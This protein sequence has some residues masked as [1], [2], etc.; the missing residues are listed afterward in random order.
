MSKNEQSLCNF[1]TMLNSI[2]DEHSTLT[3]F[4]AD[5]GASSHMTYSKQFLTNLEPVDVIIQNGNNSQ[6][7]CTQK[8][9][10]KGYMLDTQGNF[11]SISLSNVLY[12]PSLTVN[13]L[14]IT[15]CLS[16][17]NVTLSGTN[18][19]LSLSFNGS[20]VQFTKKLHRGSGTLFAVDI[21]PQE[22]PTEI[23]IESTYLTIDYIQ[24]HNMMG[25]ANK[26][27]LLKTAK[28]Q[29]IT[30]TNTTQPPC[31]HCAKAKIRMKNMPKSTTTKA[32]SKGERLFIDLAW[33]KTASFANNRYW[34]LVMDDFTNFIW[35]FFLKSKDQL[36]EKVIALLHD[37]KKNHNII[38]HHIRCDN[39]GE[40]QTLQQMLQAD[41]ILT[42][43]FE[44]TAPDTPQQNGKIERKFATLNGKVRAMLNHAEFTWT[45]RN[46][47]WS[48]CA[49]LATKLD[50]LLVI[51]PTNQTPY[52][53]FYGFTPKWIPYLQPFG[54]MAIVKH[55]DQIQAKL[56]NR[57]FP[58]IY[59]GPAEDH[60]EDVYNFWNPITRK[61]I[62]SRTAIFILQSYGKYYK[63]EPSKR[64]HLIAALKSPSTEQYDDDDP[65]DD[66]DSNNADIDV[67]L[68]DLIAPARAYDNVTTTDTDSLHDFTSDNDSDSSPAALPA[69]IL[70]R[71]SGVP[72]ALSQLQTFYNPTPGVD[73][74]SESTLFNLLSTNKYIESAYLATMFNTSPEPQTF[75]ES[76]QCHD[77]PLWWKAVSLEFM[78]MEEKQ[79]WTIILK[80]N[81]P[82]KRHIIGT[83]WVF[84]Q[85]EDGRYR[86]RCVAKGFSQI[87]GKDFQEHHAP[88]ITDTTTHL[89]FVLQTIL[90][91]SNGQFDIETAFL[92]GDLDEKLWME[93]PD[94]YI[95][96]LKEK[97]L[98]NN[99]IYINI[100]SQTHCLLLTKAIYGLVQAARQWWKKFKEVLR[101]LYYFPSRADPCLFIKTDRLNNKSYLIIYVD[102]GGIFGTPEEIKHVLT[103]LSKTFVVKDL[104]PM[105]TFVGCKIITNKSKDTVWLHQPKLFKHLKEQFGS[106]I[107]NIKIHKTPASPKTNILRPDADDVLLQPLDQTKFRSGVGMLLYLVKHTRFD[108][109]NAVRELSKVADGANQAHWKALLRT[110][111]YTIETEHLAIKLKPTLTDD[112]C[113]EL[114]GMSDSDYAGDKQTRTSVFGYIIYF[115]GAPIAWKSKASKSVTLSST[116]AEYV[117]LSEI[118]KE[119]MFVKQVLETMNIKIKLPITVR[120]DN[121]GAIYLSNNFSLGQRTKHID[122]RHHFVREFVEDGI[123]KTIFIPTNDN[124]ADIFTKNTSEDTFN[125]HTM[126]HLEDIR[127]INLQ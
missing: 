69:T 55:T 22:S 82:L 110:I 35:S 115:C 46:N 15:K 90:R 94:G 108:I 93:L 71:F 125:R 45:L 40:N 63:I 48:Y 53:L 120:V 76:Q 51:A 5:T 104:G 101:T 124:D 50:N 79:V 36:Q 113:F 89:L 9:T 25:H 96:Y 95:R 122:I 52:N 17:N 3:T 47:M 18:Q 7:S 28:Q 109:A 88:V 2:E 30:L 97:C 4:I 91:L 66:D 103:Q 20:E 102:D 118:T 92:Y 32:T 100:S 84:A 56:Q 37:L 57:G 62:Q 44:L 16:Q 121:V 49:L 81:V 38:V 114:E 78:N 64:A 26:A 70:T 54:T 127:L 73:S 21:I 86:A 106:L 98:R 33:I 8:G 12:V 61:S 80:S 119:I 60:K 99:T 105:E 31:E 34:L 42:C 29:N 67:H 24:Y 123:I 126:K 87:P 111:K 11:I 117:A 1:E 83:R 107:E 65:S 19:Y 59:L 14:S 43:N 13:L 10:Y 116:E 23:T 74:D 85:K 77:A 39:A 58:A 75:L 27:S 68:T 41:N 72:R 6:M 112:L